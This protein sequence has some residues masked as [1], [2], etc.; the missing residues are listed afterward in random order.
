MIV[1]ISHHSNK[2]NPGLKT[3]YFILFNLKA[4][5]MFPFQARTSSR[6]SDSSPKSLVSIWLG[7]MTGI[8]T[9]GA[10]TT[11]AGLKIMTI[12]GI[13][14]TGVVVAPIG[15]GIATGGLVAFL[16]YSIVKRFS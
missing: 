13:S 7:S 5:N 4:Q 16:T 14:A 15:L 8:A 1:S 3:D 9:Y 12:I 10:A 2:I 11:V 6:N